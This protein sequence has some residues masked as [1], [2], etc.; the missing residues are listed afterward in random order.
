MSDKKCCFSTRKVKDF[1][2]PEDD[3]FCRQVQ[4]KSGYLCVKNGCSR[5]KVKKV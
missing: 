4:E 1:D 3:E 5:Y 2:G